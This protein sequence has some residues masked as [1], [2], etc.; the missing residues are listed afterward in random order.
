MA[1]CCE[2]KNFNVDKI[3]TFDLEYFFLQLRAISVSDV[4]NITITESNDAEFP[5]VLNFKKIEVVFPDDAVSPII[6]IDNTTS[7]VMK[8]P[9][10][11]VYYETNEELLKRLKDKNIYDL[12]LACIDNVYQGDILLQMSPE[13][14]QEFLD[15]L[16]I[17]IYRKMKEFL[18]KMPKIEHTLVYR[19]NEQGEERFIQFSSLMDFFPFL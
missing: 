19:K 9:N 11:S 17:P 12:V 16:G 13:E 10:A 4:E 18:I 5:A 3:P 15:G 6:Q 2:E 1:A 7:L 8:Y 14:M